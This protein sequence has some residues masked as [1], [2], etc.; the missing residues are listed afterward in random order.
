MERS[1]EFVPA[2][3]ITFRYRE[4]ES[5]LSTTEIELNISE[6]ETSGGPLLFLEA[7][8]DNGK[9]SSEKQMQLATEKVNLAMQNL[10]TST[11][12]LSSQEPSWKKA[13]TA[14]LTRTA[15]WR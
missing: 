3:D 2:E 5:E 1:E 7:S 8:T 6:S 12:S 11:S 10:D 14:T 13:K 9:F 4:S 15:N